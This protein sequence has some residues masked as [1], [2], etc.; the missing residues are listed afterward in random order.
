MILI[1]DVPLVP[2][3]QAVFKVIKEGQTTPVYGDVTEDAK[4]PYITIGSVTMKPEA[5]KNMVLWTATIN[6]DVW[7]DTNGKRK[8]N[9]VLNDVSALLSYYGSTLAV[10]GYKT[11]SASID[12][13]EAFPEATT[14]YHGTL[15]SSFL[16]NKI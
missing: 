7:A 11:I 4:L 1:K 14:G 9:D 12:V 5:V 8:V 6:I 3:Q 15:T 13:I 10:D 2:L 16:L